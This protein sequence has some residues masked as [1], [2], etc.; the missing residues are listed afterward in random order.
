MSTDETYG[1]TSSVPAYTSDR[2]KILDVYAVPWL[3]ALNELDPDL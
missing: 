1:G 3:A 2:G